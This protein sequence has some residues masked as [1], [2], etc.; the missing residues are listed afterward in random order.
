MQE[1]NVLINF[2]ISFY[3]VFMTPFDWKQQPAMSL[4]EYLLSVMNRI[5]CS[6][7]VLVCALIY[8]QRYFD[9]MNQRML[10]KAYEGIFA[11]SY[12]N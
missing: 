10:E 12:R 4:Q 6:E 3:I 5:G 11:H 7:K 2:K 1:R 8:I 9:V